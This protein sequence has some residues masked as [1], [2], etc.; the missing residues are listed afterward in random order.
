MSAV[1]K[2]L[3]DEPAVKRSNLLDGYVP[4]ADTYDELMDGEGTVRP[5]WRELVAAFESLEKSEL[6]RRFATAD[7]HLRDAGVFHRVYGAD[8]G[9][10]IWPLS[11]VPL[12]IDPDEWSALEAGIAQRAELL[13]ALVADF[14]GPGTLVREGHLPAAVVAGS[15]DFLRPLVGI[16]PKG[17]YHLRV[18]A[19][20]L[21]RGPDGRWWVLSDRTQAPSGMGYVLENRIALSRSLPD[22]YRNMQ[23]SRVAPFFQALRDTLN[24]LHERENA[25]VCLLTPGPLNETYFEHAY[26]SRYLG[27]LLVEGADLV[28]RDSKLAVRTVEGA[29]PADVIWR[30]VDSDFID[31][32][33]LNPRSRLGVPGLVEAVREGNATVVNALGSAV[34]ESRALMSFLPALC[35]HVLGEELALPNVAT[36]WCGQERERNHVLETFDDLAIAPAFHPSAPG[37]FAHGPVIAADLSRGDRKTIMDAMKRRGVDFVGQEVVRLST[38][39][40][41]TGEKLEPRPCVVRAYAV[42]TPDGWTVMPGAFSRVSERMDARAVTMQQGGRAVDV[43]IPAE[44]EAPQTTLLT[45]PD[46]VQIT[47]RTGT[48]PARAADNLFWLGRYMERAETCLRL[49]RAVAQ[50]M[51][52]RDELDDRLIARLRGALVGLGAVKLA[53]RQTLTSADMVGALFNAELPGSAIS[54]VRSARTAASGIRERLSPQAWRELAKLAGLFEKPLPPTATD[55]DIIDAAD[56]SLDLLAGFAGLSQEN[57]NRLLGWRFLEMGRRIERAS[58]TCS[59][60]ERFIRGEIV[61]GGLDVLLEYADS[62][63]SYRV[64][65]ATSAGRPAVLDMVVLDANNPRSI[66][67]QIGVIARTLDA[68]PIQKPDGLPTP[69]EKIVALLVAELATTAAADVDAAALGWVRMQVM[70]LSELLTSRFFVQGNVAAQG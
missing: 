26:L 25:R 39:P 14:Y 27:F 62:Q 48:L 8:E 49:I 58:A 56:E 22:I 63:I 68:L 33:E 59:V 30:R 16:E 51:A 29:Q 61:R 21:G 2:S 1:E 42:R 52:D 17:G 47:R 41:W 28:V 24:S 46:E 57:M 6:E 20:D 69:E 54:L 11:H 37:P 67:F 5:H 4:L 15:D 66:A 19:C 65:Y 36:W 35:Q 45:E 55:G 43:W 13:E 60:V 44:E 53:E 40:V 7:R 31:P 70:K 9:E 3:A 10:R 18:Y 23:V 50:R 34:L 32:L 64:R 38:T 12:V